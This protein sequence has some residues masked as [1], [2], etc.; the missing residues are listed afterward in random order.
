MKILVKTYGQCFAEEEI[1][2]SM[3][4]FSASEM[5]EVWIKTTRRQK[6]GKNEGIWWYKEVVPTEITG[7]FWPALLLRAKPWAG[8]DSAAKTLHEDLS[9]AAQM[10]QAW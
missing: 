10:L 7:K 6:G 2:T 4:M 5:V 3:M 9:S 8:D 1:H